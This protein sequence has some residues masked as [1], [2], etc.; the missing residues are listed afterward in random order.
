MET[1]YAP[2]EHPVFQLTPPLFD[3]MAQKLYANLGRP[4]VSSETFWDVY[5]A[6]LNSVRAVDD[7][8]DFN[9]APQSSEHVEADEIIDELPLL[10]NLRELRYGDEIAGPQRFVYAGGLESPPR[11]MLPTDTESM[12]QRDEESGSSEWPEEE[13]EEEVDYRV[14]AYL[15]PER[16]VESET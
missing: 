7:A 12:Q 14:R 6:L 5:T 13:D 11:N 9:D 10:P 1:R 15:T 4:A 2:P 8:S 3:D 16:S